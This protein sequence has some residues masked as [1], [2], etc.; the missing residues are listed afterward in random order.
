MPRM[1]FERRGEI[2]TKTK[3]YAEGTKVHARD[4]KHEGWV[5]KILSSEWD[6]QEK[7]HWYMVEWVNGI[8]TLTIPVYHEDLV[9]VVDRYA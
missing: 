9:K 8:G 3:P 6:E 5:G 2:V 4:P 7:E 1:I